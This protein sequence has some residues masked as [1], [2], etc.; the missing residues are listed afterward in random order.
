MSDNETPA[1]ESVR[2]P[3][4]R[5]ARI[6]GLTAIVAGILAAVGVPS[7]YSFDGGTTFIGMLILFLNIVGYVASGVLALRGAL[8]VAPWLVVPSLLLYVFVFLI[9]YGSPGDLLTTAFGLSGLVGI[10]SLIFLLI[11]F[12]RRPRPVTTRK[13]PHCAEMIKVEA[14]ACRYCGRDITPAVTPDA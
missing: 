13:C 14:T 1:S 5:P 9:V 11:A 12:A 2:D 10:V 6:G 4:A 7:M 3:A 8:N